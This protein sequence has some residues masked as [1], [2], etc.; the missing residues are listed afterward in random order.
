VQELAGRWHTLINA[1][2][3]GDRSV[4]S[5]M[6]AKLDGDDAE[7]ATKGIVTEEAWEYIKRA[8]AVGFSTA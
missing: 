7:R 5:A 6:Y 3:S 4:V 1:M 8:F 2:T